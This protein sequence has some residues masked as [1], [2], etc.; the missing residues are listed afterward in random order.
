MGSS[1]RNQG[2]GLAAADEVYLTLHCRQLCGSERL[3]MVRLDRL[4]RPNRT[5]ASTRLWP[6]LTA[7]RP[8]PNR[9]DAIQSRRHRI[10]RPLYDALRSVVT[11]PW[12]ALD[13]LS[14]PPTR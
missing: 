11:D 13:D 9:G 4:G 6:A 7:E 3:P 2:C 1:G 8:N 14:S 10:G 12:P 5:V